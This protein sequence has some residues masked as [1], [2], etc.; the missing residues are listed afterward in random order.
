MDKSLTDPH[1]RPVCD[2]KKPSFVACCSKRGYSHEPTEPYLPFE[3]QR[4]V[5]WD[6]PPPDVLMFPDGVM[7][8]KNAR[9]LEAGERYEYYRPVMASVNTEGFAVG[10]S[11]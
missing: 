9:Y 5:Y 3:F 4:L 2:P 6:G 10:W 1:Y 7:V 11:G 8:V